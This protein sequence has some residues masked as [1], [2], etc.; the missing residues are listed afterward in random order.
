MHSGN[1]ENYNFI[2]GLHR[3]LINGKWFPLHPHTLGRPLTHDEMDYNLLYTQQTVAGWRIFGQNDNLTLSDNELK[4][5][6]IFW[7]ISADDVDYARYVAAGYTVDQYIWITPTHDCS[8]FMASSGSTSDASL[9]TI[10]DAFVIT[11]SSTS[12]TIDSCDIFGVNSQGATDSV[13]YVT[14]PAPTPEPTATEVPPTATPAPTATGVP[15]TA[16]PTPTPTPTS[17]ATATPTPTATVD[18]RKRTLKLWKVI[19]PW[20]EDSSARCDVDETIDYWAEW[21]IGTTSPSTGKYVTGT[22]GACYKVVAKY[23]YDY[24]LPEGVEIN[25][26][27]IGGNYFTECDCGLPPTPTPTPSPTPNPA[28]LSHLVYATGFNLNGEWWSTES[29]GPGIDP[30]LTGQPIA[31]YANQIYSDYY[32]NTDGSA[33]ALTFGNELTQFNQPDNYAGWL[34]NSFVGWPESKWPEQKAFKIQNISDLATYRAR[35]DSSI[36]ELPL[37]VTPQTGLAYL[38]EGIGQLEIGM[39]LY[40]S[41]ASGRPE[42]LPETGA[43]LVSQA[44]GGRYSSDPNQTWELPQGSL[45]NE[46]EDM[47]Q[48]AVG[49]NILR[50]VIYENWVVKRVMDIAPGLPYGSNDGADSALYP[51]LGYYDN[52]DWNTLVD[53][54]FAANP[55][56]S[57]GSGLP[58]AV[59]GFITGKLADAGIDVPSPGSGVLSSSH[60][61]RHIL[62]LYVN[63]LGGTLDTALLEEFGIDQGCYATPTAT[64]TATPV[65]PT[66]TPT[67]TPTPT[68]DPSLTRFSWLLATDESFA[69]PIDAVLEDLDNDPNECWS[70]SFL[71][72]QQDAAGMQLEYFPIQPGNTYYLKLNDNIPTDIVLQNYQLYSSGLTLEHESIGGLNTGFDLSPEQICGTGDVPYVWVRDANNAMVYAHSPSNPGWV[73]VTAETKDAFG[74]S[75]AASPG[76]TSYGHSGTWEPTYVKIQVPEEMLVGSVFKFETSAGISYAMGA[77]GDRR[78]KTDHLDFTPG[79]LSNIN[80]RVVRNPNLAPTPTPTPTYDLS[81]AAA[82]SQNGQWSLHVTDHDSGA[83]INPVIVDITQ[84]YN[85]SGG[86]GSLYYKYFPIAANEKIKVHV[87]QHSGTLNPYPNLVVYNQDGGYTHDSI[88]NTATVGGWRPILTAFSDRDIPNYNTTS[89]FIDNKSGTDVLPLLNHPNEMVQIALNTPSEQFIV[90]RPD[91]LGTFGNT[92]MLWINETGAGS[93]M[94]INLISL[95]DGMTPP[96][97]YEEL[98]T[99][100]TQ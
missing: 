47:Q 37:S 96:T 55:N 93:G 63:V 14:E 51:Q 62:W 21:P 77:D 9:N 36:T 12:P 35:Y 8:D 79:L 97:T 45:V 38:G 43:I 28:E 44:E 54:W 80:F 40:S 48:S 70:N 50:Y 15:P 4:K 88:D 49:S 17:T 2:H 72:R 71:L 61:T 91:G 18:V 75:T 46:V 31:V 22:D 41:G 99:P 27:L 100:P 25:L 5:S 16:T 19:N 82:V 89:G 84:E 20:N 76:F 32:D 23:Q 67:P 59:T 29:Y 56:C 68:L 81:S 39:T 60:R 7:K 1:I 53:D 57:N 86:T 58:S 92:T 98:G 95:P 85:A 13:G 30:A 33:V 64:P 42:G 34:S 73:P 3:N 78:T 94:M 87:E 90:G 11:L 74:G 66:A 65:P 26:T 6:L 83:V 52:Q 10:C 24:V 69:E